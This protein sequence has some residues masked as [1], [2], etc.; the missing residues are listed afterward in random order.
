[1]AL[2]GFHASF[3]QF[4][5]YLGCR[6]SDFYIYYFELDQFNRYPVSNKIKVGGQCY[7]RRV[8][9]VG[10]QRDSCR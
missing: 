8:F 10:S 6:L 9:P 1:M 3:E 4:H 2:K 7:I 5:I